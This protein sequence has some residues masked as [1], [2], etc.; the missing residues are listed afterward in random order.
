MSEVHADFPVAGYY[1]MRAFKGGPY[2]P[3]V[4]W[5]HEGKLV[6]RVGAEMREP[7][8]IWTYCAKN[9]VS[10]DDAKHAFEHGVWPNEA[11]PPALGDNQPPSDDP[12]EAL[13]REIDAEEARVEAWVAEPHEG[14]AKAELAS[15]WLAALRRLESRTVDAFDAEKAPVLAESKR[16]DSKW[17]D[18]KARALAIKKLMDDCYQGIGRREKARL[19][20]I[21]DRKAKAEAEERKKQ[22][23]LD[24]IRRMELAAEHNM[25]IVPEPEPEIV[26]VVAPVKVAFGGAAGGPK[27][28]VRKIPPQ[29]IIEDWAKCAAFYAS[30]QK[31]RDVLTKLVA[32]DVRDGRLDLPGVKIIPGEQ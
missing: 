2:Q 9:K 6:A 1:K 8:D 30:H 12:F 11:P 5:E 25:P 24:Q 22:W 17:R 18:L 16:I 20:E 31:L 10:K 29:P 23:E 19:Q 4:I 3:V 26:P 13:T 21:A 7:T 32:H 27:I 28:A 14:A 15:N